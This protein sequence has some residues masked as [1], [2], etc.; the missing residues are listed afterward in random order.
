M[1]ETK[2][3]HLGDV[4]SMTT[5]RLVSPEHMAGVY[6]IA[7]YLVGRAVYTHE[8]PAAF[9]QCR[10]PLLDQHPQLRQVDDSGVTKDNWRA[11]LDQ[12]VERFGSHLGVRPVWTQLAEMDALETAVELVGEGR[13]I[14][15][16]PD[17]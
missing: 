5:G 14:V 8:I 12:Q 15:V 4:L 11:W 3:F 7:S 6:K 10:D 1:S 13:V 16:D 2:S 17:A 9:R